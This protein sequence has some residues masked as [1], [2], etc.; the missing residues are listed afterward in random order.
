V[1][2]NTCSEL[3]YSHRRQRAP[4][5]LGAQAGQQTCKLPAPCVSG[6]VSRALVRSKLAWGARSS[7]PTN[8]FRAAF[9]PS[10]RSISSLGRASNFWPLTLL[11]VSEH[12]K[13]TGRIQRAPAPAPPCGGKARTTPPNT[14]LRPERH[15][16]EIVG[17][18]DPT[19]CRSADPHDRRTSSTVNTYRRRARALRFMTAVD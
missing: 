13:L 14:C 16:R 15:V 5:R 6:T 9:A 10:I 7:V 8:F 11:E 1:G 4:T 19:G 3:S 18:C 12:A 17:G 2:E